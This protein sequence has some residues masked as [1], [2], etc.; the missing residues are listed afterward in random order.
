[1]A[2]LKKKLGK[3]QRQLKFLQSETDKE[4]RWREEERENITEK[5]RGNKEMVTEI[6]RQFY[7]NLFI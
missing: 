6:D 2:H 3:D 5:I 1:M 7:G 4:K